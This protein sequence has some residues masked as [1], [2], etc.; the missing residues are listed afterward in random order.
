MHAVCA[1]LTGDIASHPH[2]DKAGM[3][4]PPRIP[5][6]PGLYNTHTQVVRALASK[7]VP[8]GLV[9]MTTHAA[10]DRPWSSHP[11]KV[12]TEQPV[13]SPNQAC[14]CSSM[15]E[16][17]QCVLS[18]SHMKCGL[19]VFS[20]FGGRFVFPSTRQEKRQNKKHTS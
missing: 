11:H 8:A 12:C 7:A 9:L 1:C 17:P 2:H 5:T 18:A 19:H 15:L 6:G 3:N 16:A 13:F 4:T 20:V 14:T 10:V